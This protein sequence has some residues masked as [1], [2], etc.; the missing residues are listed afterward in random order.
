[1]ALGMASIVSPVGV[2]T[3]IIQHKSNG[4]IAETT[5]EWETALRNLLENE[6]L[7]K[8]L[9]QNATESIQ[10][11]WSVEVWKENYL[12]LLIING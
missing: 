7:R 12:K 11:K 4:L 1:M 9:G 8:E 5:E 3:R 6:T 10:Q 2:N